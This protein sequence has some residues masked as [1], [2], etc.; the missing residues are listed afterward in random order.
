[1]KEGFSLSEHDPTIPPNCEVPLSW[2]FHSNKKF[3]VSKTRSTRN[4]TTNNAQIASKF[5]VQDT[6]FECLHK[7]FR[8]STRR[9]TLLGLVRHSPR[10]HFSPSPVSTH[11]PWAILKSDLLLWTKPH[12]RGS[13]VTI[14]YTRFIGSDVHAVTI[15]VAIADA[16]RRPA[17]FEGTIPADEAAVRQWIQRQ[18][19]ARSS[20]VSRPHRP[21]LGHLRCVRLSDPQGTE[22]YRFPDHIGPAPS[23]KG[24]AR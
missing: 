15:A 9:V 11:I 7:D 2:D 1:M 17:Q 8:I 3:A 6:K 24:S 12:T 21:I 20:P 13:G 14:E 23:Q 18:F 22:R 19:N 16:G 10:Y 4:L 5:S